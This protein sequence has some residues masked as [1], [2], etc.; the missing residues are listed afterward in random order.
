MLF[1]IN[2]SW[3]DRYVTFNIVPNVAT[4][5]CWNDD[6]VKFSFVNDCVTTH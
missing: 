4:D 1:T 5:M 2:Q 6:C 3:P